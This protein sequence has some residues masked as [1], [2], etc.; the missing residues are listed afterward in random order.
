MNKANVMQ[1][2]WENPSLGWT[3]WTKAVHTMQRRILDTMLL[4]IKESRAIDVRAMMLI[5]LE[6]LPH[7]VGSS[8]QDKY[9][10]R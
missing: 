3:S 9:Q 6:M 10:I 8:Q 4:H 5:S 1:N 7:N 2:V